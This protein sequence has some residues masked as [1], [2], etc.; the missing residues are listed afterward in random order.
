MSLR[1]KLLLSYV[2]VVA[3]TLVSM[4]WFARQ[5]AVREVDRFMTAQ[6]MLEEADL[7]RQFEVYYTRMGTWQ[8][9]DTIL[10][11]AG[12]KGMNG[13]MM[14]GQRIRVID[15]AGIVVADTRG[16]TGILVDGSLLSP[17]VTLKDNS[18]AVIGYLLAEAGTGSGMMRFGQQDQ[19]G[20]NLLNR[21]SN[22]SLTAA[23]I[24]GSLALLIAF[25]FGYVLLKPVVELTQAARK[26]AGGDLSQ[27]V[28]VSGTDELAELGR[29]FN[30]MSETLQRSELNRKAMTADVAHELRTPIAVQRA[31]LEALQDGVYPLTAENLQPILDQTELLAR[32]VDDLRTL[33]LVDAGELKIER[34]FIPPL[35]LALQVVERFR[36]EADQ[37]QVEMRLQVNGGDTFPQVNVD[38][39]RIEQILNNLVGNAL[40]HTPGGGEILISLE[41]GKDRI[42]M[43]VADTGSGIPPDALSHIFE[44]FYR[45]DR[46]RSR[47]DGGTGLG[48]AIAKQ[49]ALVHGGDLTAKNRPPGGA[50]FTLELP[51]V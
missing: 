20:A 43:R 7:A 37:R 32:L 45:A 4:V 19:A 9:V 23:A 24:G 8:G 3:V 10:P 5:G 21:L 11:A 36:A 13:G 48:L 15:A 30:T 34:Q 1:I 22:A 2:L 27:R 17:A 46:A 18:G 12:G 33:A 6:G 42:A 14:G 29:T 28:T 44:R 41:Q 16:E 35:D 38:K 39:R 51:V 47:E 26:M 50:E 40:K 49:L 25:V 31:H